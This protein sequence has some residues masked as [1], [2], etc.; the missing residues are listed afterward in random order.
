MSHENKK[1]KSNKIIAI[2]GPTASGKTALS[3]AVAKHF[4][5]EVVSCDSMQIYK[6]MDIG[7]AKP[8]E[9]EMSGIRHHMIDIIEP[10]ENYNVVSFKKDAEAVIDEI[11][12]RGKLPVLVGG[13]G[14][15]MDSVLNNVGFTETK[16][17]E[18][19]RKELTE[20]WE[21]MGSEYMHAELEKI[22]P[23]SAE[24][25]HP[26]NVRRVIRALEI[27]RTTGKT[28]TQVN[29]ESKREPKYDSL[30][31]GLMWD[32]EVLN[33][34]IN[35]RVDI[36]MEK[37]LLDEV[38][39]LKASGLK[40]ELTSMQAI[41]YKELFEYF[42]GLVTLDEAV[43]KIKLESRRYAKRQMTW[44]RRNEKINWLMLQKDYNLNKIYEQCFTMAEKFGIMKNE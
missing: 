20:L 43:E 44:L 24:K 33:E 18:A 32:R 29:E 28:M 41:G 26:N 38:E 30:V 1:Q 4:G 17:D 39:E 27:Y 9:E 7:T 10:D 34:R 13:T 31:F 5:G 42:D 25:I 16:S 40:R 8:D 19:V 11:L 35:R 23:E 2:A 36:M 3:I 12:E 37:G 15:Y 14:L 22:D 6:R 21:K